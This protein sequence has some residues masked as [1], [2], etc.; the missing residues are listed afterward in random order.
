MQ[1]FKINEI[2]K[3]SSKGISSIL[4]IISSQN[5]FQIVKTEF[6]SGLSGREVYFFPWLGAKPA[7]IEK[8]CDQLY[9]KFNQK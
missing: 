8:Y 5:H 9:G 1:N 2:H 6:S 3:Q 7:H 4:K